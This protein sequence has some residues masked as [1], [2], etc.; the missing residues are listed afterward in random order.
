MGTDNLFSGGRGRPLSRGN[1]LASSVARHG[2]ARFRSLLGARPYR[3]PFDE[4][5]APHSGAATPGTFRLDHP[6]GERTASAAVCTADRATPWRATEEAPDAF[7]L[8]SGGLALRSR[9]AEKRVPAAGGL[10]LLPSKSLS[11]FG[12][13]IG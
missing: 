5:G 11:L 1:A 6:P 7:L 13:A 8:E 10:G 2:V 12:I 3:P 4:E 9:F